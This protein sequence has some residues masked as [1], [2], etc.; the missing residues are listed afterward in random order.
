[1]IDR[2]EKFKGNYT[3]RLDLQRFAQGLY[4]LELRSGSE[5]YNKKVIKK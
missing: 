4:I 3:Y 5:I 1:M 2:I